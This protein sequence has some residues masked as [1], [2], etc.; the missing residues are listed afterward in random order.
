MSH[1]TDGRNIAVLVLLDLSQ[2]L[3]DKA[4]GSGEQSVLE[5][6]QEAVSLLAW[7]SSNWATRLPLPASTP[8]PATT[9]ATCTSRALASASTTP[10]RAAW[11]PCRPATAPAWAPPCA[12]PRALPGTQKADKKLLLVLTDGQPADIDVHDERLLIEDARRPC[13][14]ST[15]R[16][17]H[18]LHQP[19]P[20]GRRLRERHFWPALHGDR[21]HRSACPSSLPKLFMA[22]TR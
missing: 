5:L 10:S 22:L 18:L 6:S 1:R 12:T 20:Q 3:N 2:S 13:A 14:S 8:T 11:R 4:R 17:L 19:G 7:A 21:Q 15:A 9:C 16:H